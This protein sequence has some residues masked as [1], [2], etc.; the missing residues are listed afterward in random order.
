MVTHSVVD[1]AGLLEVIDTSA[2][3]DL[4]RSNLLRLQISE[5]LEECQLDL[6][7]RRWNV[8][9]QAYFQRLSAIIAG[10]SVDVK[11]FQDLADKPVS[12]ELKG[13]LKLSMEPIGCTKARFGWTKKAG[14]A[15]VPPTFDYMV[16]IP[17]EVFSGKDYMH[18]RYFDV[19]WPPLVVTFFTLAKLTLLVSPLETKCYYESSRRNYF[20][21]R[22]GSGHGQ[23]G[24]D[25]WH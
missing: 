21:T 7:S 19:R 8:T 17:L 13:G 24:V 4:H 12:V 16:Q 25:S 23:F 2:T 20:Q 14:N 11:D 9:T 22:R 6:E 1:D 18:H 5:L 10:V 3:L 15:H